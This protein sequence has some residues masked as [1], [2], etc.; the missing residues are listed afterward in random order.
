MRF[1]FLAFNALIFLLRDSGLILMF[2]TV[3]ALHE[4]GHLAVLRLTGGT[5]HTVTLSGFGIVITPSADPLRSISRDAAVLIAGPFANIIMYLLMTALNCRGDFPMM[6]L[7]AALY[8]LL[9]FPGLDG[10][11]LCELFISGTPH[12]RLL[13]RCMTVL[14]VLLTAAAVIWC[15]CAQL[16]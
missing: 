11:A 13:R 14:Q 12:E 9:P 2:Y 15:M 5:V 7:A 16:Q 3:C 8:N 4:A 10:G 6:N 1:S